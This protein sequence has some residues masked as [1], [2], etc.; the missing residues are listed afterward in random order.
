MP[1]WDLGHGMGCK[2]G[3]DPGGVDF[4]LGNTKHWSGKGCLLAAVG[5][6][7]RGSEGI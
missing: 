2:C 3:E 5:L 7:R 6:G 1:V 4:A